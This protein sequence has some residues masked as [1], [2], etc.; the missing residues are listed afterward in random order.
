MAGT[1]YR[2]VSLYINAVAV[3]CIGKLALESSLLIDHIRGLTNPFVMGG[4]PHF[5]SLGIMTAEAIGWV[6]TKCQTGMRSVW[7]A[8]QIGSITI[9]INVVTA[10]FFCTWKR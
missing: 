7:I 5:L 2:P 1:T 4:I 8:N 10:Y 9:L 6:F 3:Y